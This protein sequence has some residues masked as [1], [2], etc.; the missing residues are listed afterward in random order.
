MLY[1]KE[2]CIELQKTGNKITNLKTL[3]VIGHTFPEP[4]TTAA[5]SRMMQLLQLFQEDNYSITFA[6]TATV[7]EKSESFENL[8]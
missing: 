6:S 4:S 8:N 2:L 3:L 1:L 7:S 5:G